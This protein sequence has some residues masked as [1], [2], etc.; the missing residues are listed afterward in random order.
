MGEMDAE[1]K[2]DAATLQSRERYLLEPGRTITGFDG[3][4]LRGR[5]HFLCLCFPGSNRGDR[6]RGLRKERGTE[7]TEQPQ[8][9]LN[10][11]PTTEKSE[12]IKTVTSFF[13]SWATKAKKL[14]LLG[15]QVNI[16]V[17]VTDMQIIWS[18]ILT[19]HLMY[20]M[21]AETSSQFFTDF[22]INTSIDEFSFCLSV[23]FNSQ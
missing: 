17:L 13:L 4:A 3:W 12:I 11:I 1:L 2:V 15:L 23:G 14:L 16:I 5:S 10:V 8:Q 7:S 19:N 6:K 18:I 21:S 9:S 20:N 22:L